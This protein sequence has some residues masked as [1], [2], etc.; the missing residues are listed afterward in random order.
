MGN[1][2]ILHSNYPFYSGNK[3]IIYPVKIIIDFL[4]HEKLQPDLVTLGPSFSS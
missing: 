4:L 3:I 1:L 2:H